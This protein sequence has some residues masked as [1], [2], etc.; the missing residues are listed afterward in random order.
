[1]NDL[2]NIQKDKNGQNIVSARELHQFLE[3]NQKFA[4]WIKNRIEKYELTENQD[5]VVF[6]NFRKNP[7]GGRSLTEYALS[8]FLS[9]NPKLQ[10]CSLE[11]YQ[12]ITTQNYIKAFTRKS[13]NSDNQTTNLNFY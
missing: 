7:Q 13:C 12:I 8:S 2:I 3:S 10:N 11:F 5:F 1:M 6:H 9:E 4:D